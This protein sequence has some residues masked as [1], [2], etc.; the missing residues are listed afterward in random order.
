MRRTEL[1]GQIP[2]RSPLAEEL[3]LP[4]GRVMVPDIRTRVSNVKNVLKASG[5]YSIHSFYAV[6]I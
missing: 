4:R 5:C 2:F 6:I 1:I 3:L